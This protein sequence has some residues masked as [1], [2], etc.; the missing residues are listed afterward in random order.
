MEANR[1]HRI[2]VVDDEQ[3]IVNAVTRELHSPPLG[4]RHYTVEGFTAPLLA[5]ERSRQQ[6]FDAVICDFRMPQMSGLDFLREFAILQPDC[7]RLVLSGQTDMDALIRM[8]NE[9]RIYRFI[10]KPW[11][12]YYLKGSVAQAV[13]YARSIA[14]NRRLAAQ[15]RAQGISAA[16]LVDSF[17]QLLVVDDDPGVLNALSR[18]LTRRAQ[19]DDLFAA[20]RADLADHPGP[21]LEEGKLNVQITASPLQAL[22]MAE[23]VS[24]SCVIADFRMPEM[25]GVELL[26][27]LGDSQPDCVRI[28]ISGQIQ[29]SELIHAVD[30][31]HIFAFFAKP[32]SDFELKSCIAQA[33]ACR[34]LELENRALA[35][36]VK[37]AGQPA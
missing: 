2:L 21:L 9:T 12:D 33:L 28:L 25:N 35:D 26:Q 30:S 10:P 29:E 8:I 32:W 19:S 13:D 22:R 37:A 20:I 4:R 17:D 16:Q 6:A 5:L 1:S 27:R 31:A 34:R 24:F 11:H 14:D 3:G 36:M 15:V 23:A 18:I 7:A